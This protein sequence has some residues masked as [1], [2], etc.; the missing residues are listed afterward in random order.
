MMPFYDNY[1]LILP[2]KTPRINVFLCLDNRFRV[3]EESEG[4]D[5]DPVRD[6]GVLG[7]R[8]HPQ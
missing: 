1:V 6:P 5:L 3:C 4:S 2:L 8:D 7:P